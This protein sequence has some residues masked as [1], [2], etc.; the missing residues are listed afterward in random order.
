M[1]QSTR[2]YL[3][4]ESIRVYSRTS[5]NHVSELPTSKVKV[6]STPKIFYAKN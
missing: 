4:Q 3:E 5:I 2:T 6:P 1:A